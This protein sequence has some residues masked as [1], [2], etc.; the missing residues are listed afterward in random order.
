MEISEGTYLLCDL[1]LDF[2]TECKFCTCLTEYVQ[3]CAELLGKPTYG[4]KP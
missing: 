4:P 1:I 2:A 3:K